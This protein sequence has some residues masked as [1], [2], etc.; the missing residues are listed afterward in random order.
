MLNKNIM[1]KNNIKVVYIDNV[2]M[3]TKFSKENSRCNIKCKP[4]I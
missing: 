2:K 3:L 4:F 1:S